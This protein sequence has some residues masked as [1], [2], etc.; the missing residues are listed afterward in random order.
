MVVRWVP[1]NARALVC[2]PGLL[3]VEPHVISWQRMAEGVTPRDLEQAWVRASRV[4]RLA[5][6]ERGPVQ[7]EVV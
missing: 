1:V 5:S 3:R 6:G 2:R 7:H 4:P